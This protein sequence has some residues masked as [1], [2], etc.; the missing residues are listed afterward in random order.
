MRHTLTSHPSVIPV[1]GR[2]LLRRTRL[3]IQTGEW[4]VKKATPSPFGGGYGALSQTI[5]AIGRTVIIMTC[6]ENPFILK[7]SSQSPTREGRK[8]HTTAPSQR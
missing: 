4:G 7:E 3:L 6:K 1:S 2:G 8:N 5:R